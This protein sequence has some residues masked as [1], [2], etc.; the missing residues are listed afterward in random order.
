MVRRETGAAVAMLRSA[1]RRQ[2]DRPTEGVIST[3]LQGTHD[4]QRTKRDNMRC[5]PRA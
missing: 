4:T 1:S 2:V 5:G 3:L